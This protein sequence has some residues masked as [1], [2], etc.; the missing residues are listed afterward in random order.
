[1]PGS[2]STSKHEGRRRALA[3]LAALGV[4]VSAS[5]RGAWA[6]DA[7]TGAPAGSQ[8]GANPSAGGPRGDRTL[9]PEEEDFTNTP[10]TE[11]GEFNEEE[12]EAADTRFFQYGRFF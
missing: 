7:D 1:M 6:A 12:E 8:S 9:Q 10:Y 3:T 11:Y 5:P 2:T 4:L